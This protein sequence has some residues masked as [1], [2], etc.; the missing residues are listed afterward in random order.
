MVCLAKRKTRGM[1][2]MMDKSQFRILVADDDA[3]VRDVIVKFLSGQG[4]DVLTANDGLEALQLLSIEDVHL[5]LTDLKMPGADGIEVLRTAA[6]INPK[7][8]VVILTAYGTLDIALQAVREGAYDYV[9]KPF[10]LQQLL[11]VVRNAYNLSL[12]HKENDRLLSQLRDSQRNRE[13]A[14]P[15]KAGV[16]AAMPMDALARIEK[17]E[18]LNLINS[19]EATVLK[20]RLQSKDEN[21]RKYDSLVQDLKKKYP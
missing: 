20:E 1:R 21:I 4:Y 18:D 16:H 17:L 15:D 10:V 19:D 2:G 3:M 11:L 7:I 13:E 9:A 6:R 14:K 12:L 8:A 5:V